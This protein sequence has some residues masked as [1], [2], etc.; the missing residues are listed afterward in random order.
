MPSQLVKCSNRVYV[1]KEN[2]LHLRAEPFHKGFTRT[3]SYTD[4]QNAIR[5]YKTGLQIKIGTDK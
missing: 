3:T 4:K 2:F 1:A 5:Y